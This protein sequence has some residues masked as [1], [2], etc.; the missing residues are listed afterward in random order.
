M[1]SKKN[2]VACLLTQSEVGLISGGVNF[3]KIGEATSNLNKKIDKIVKDVGQKV[4]NF[5]PK[6]EVENAMEGI[7]Q[8]AKDFKEGR[9]E[10]KKKEL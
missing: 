10:Q 7:K 4:E 6:Q 3:K 2:V 5:D 1:L 9:D 8:A